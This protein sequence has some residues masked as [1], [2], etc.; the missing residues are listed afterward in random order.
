[1]SCQ[2]MGI[3]FREGKPAG[4]CPS[5]GCKEIA[6]RYSLRRYDGVGL[7]WQFW[8]VV[9]DRFAAARDDGWD[10]EGSLRGGKN[11]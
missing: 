10:S 2:R 9:M 3:R 7:G 8:S 6:S 11:P 5:L 1:M 4:H